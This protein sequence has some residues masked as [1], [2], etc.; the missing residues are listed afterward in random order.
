MIKSSPNGQEKLPNGVLL[1][2]LGWKYENITETETRY[3]LAHECARCPCLPRLTGEQIREWLGTL[4]QRVS[5]TPAQGEIVKIKAFNTALCI[6]VWALHRCSWIVHQS[7][8]IDGSLH[9]YCAPMP[10][11]PPIF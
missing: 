10:S 6:D 1:I 7:I 3:P 4:A 11:N 9:P 8:Y 2:T 5:Q